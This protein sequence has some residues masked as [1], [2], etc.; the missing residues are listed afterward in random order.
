MR[1]AA[2]LVFP[3]L[4]IAISAAAYA[5][6]PQSNRAPVEKRI[7]VDKLTL[8]RALNEQSAPAMNG[9]G[10][11]SGSNPD[12]QMINPITGKL[13][14]QTIVSIPLTKGGPSSAS[15][16]QRRQQRE[17]CARGR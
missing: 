14:A 13:Q 10:C 4:A 1:L 11:I 15:A 6:A 17:A 9:G 16:T 5:Q 8:S 7:Q 12:A 2:V 3:V